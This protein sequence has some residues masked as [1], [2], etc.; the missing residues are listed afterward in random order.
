[1]CVGGGREKRRRLKKRVKY[2]VLA[3]GKCPGLLMYVVEARPNALAVDPHDPGALAW[4]SL[5][6]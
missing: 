5:S 4:T 1:M 3:Q 6:R 2:A